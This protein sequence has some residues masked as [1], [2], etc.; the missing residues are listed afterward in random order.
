MAEVSTGTSAASSAIGVFGAFFG[1]GAA[2]DL[3][4]FRDTMIRCGWRSILEAQ[5]AAV[6]DEGAWWSEC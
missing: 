6:G 4:A 3:G 1:L 5:M 2:G